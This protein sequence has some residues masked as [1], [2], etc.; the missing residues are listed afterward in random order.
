MTLGRMIFKPWRHNTNQL[1][2]C[3]NVLYIET[4][5]N[6]NSNQISMNSNHLIM[7]K[8]LQMIIQQ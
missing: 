3:S 6:K 5:L 1:V 4:K 7:K 2:I 8:Q